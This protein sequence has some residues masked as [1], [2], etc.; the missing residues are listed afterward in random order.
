MENIESET[1][2]KGRSTVYCEIGFV[3]IT[4]IPCKVAPYFSLFPLNSTS[5]HKLNDMQF[6][7]S[8]K[9]VYPVSSSAP[10]VYHSR[11]FIYP[12]ES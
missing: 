3:T 5:V 11:N 8:T 12:G 1:M 9:M 7:R 2:D 6:P 10:E 4:M